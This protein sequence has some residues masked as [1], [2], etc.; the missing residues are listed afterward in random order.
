MSNKNNFKNY[1]IECHKYLIFKIISLKVKLET[2][3]IITCLLNIEN[4]LS[5][6]IDVGHIAKT[7]SKSWAFKNVLSPCPDCGFAVDI[8][9]TFGSSDLGSFFWF[10][11]IVFYNIHMCF[12]VIVF[13]RPVAYSEYSNTENT[14]I[15]K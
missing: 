12:S 8:N 2:A 5:F 1:I 9:I 10:H 13:Q 4:F 6:C 11:M 7:V 14:I 3:P 15:F